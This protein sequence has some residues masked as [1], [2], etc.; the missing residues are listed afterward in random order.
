MKKQHVPPN[1]PHIKG[2][3]CFTLIL[4]AEIMCVTRLAVVFFYFYVLQ[5]RVFLPK[6]ERKKKK[7]TSCMQVSRALNR[8]VR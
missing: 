8:T 5:D 1:L 2:F 6:T 7:P 3:S 4:H